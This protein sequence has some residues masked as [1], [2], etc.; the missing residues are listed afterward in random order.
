MFK[1]SE[2]QVEKIAQLARI[3]LS[4]KEKTKFSRQLTEILGY[5]E[6][7]NRVDTKNIEITSQV[8]GLENVCREDNADEKTQV[9]KDKK[10]NREEMLANAPSQQDGYIKVKAVLE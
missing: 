10:K 1:L 3:E 4:E 5:V 8:T 2:Q 9:D 6:K 7:L